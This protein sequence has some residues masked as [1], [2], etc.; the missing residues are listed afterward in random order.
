MNAEDASSVM[1]S[2]DVNP[3]WAEAEARLRDAGVVSSKPEQVAETYAYQTPQIYPFY[4]ASPYASVAMPS[5]A[6]S[7]YNWPTMQPYPVVPPPPPPR[8][9]HHFQRPQRIDSTRV[10]FSKLLLKLFLVYLF[11]SFRLY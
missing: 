9:V 10:P 5:V 6:E 3:F 2:S 11:F 8:P 7:A 1:S 4:G